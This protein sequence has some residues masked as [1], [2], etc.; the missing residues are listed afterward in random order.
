M[1]ATLA[2]PLPGGAGRLTLRLVLLGAVLLLAVMPALNRLPVDSAL[3]VS[4]F[5]ISITGKWITY[6][7]LALAIDLAWG[8]AGILS[9]GHGAFFALGGYAM[10]MHLMRMI[11]PR[12]RRWMNSMMATSTKTLAS[13]AP[14]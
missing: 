5:L 9:L 14:A 1:S 11:G 3:H 7:I 13:T 2:S 8:Y 6:A 12:G 10:G 4:D